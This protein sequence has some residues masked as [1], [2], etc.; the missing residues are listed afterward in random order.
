MKKIVF[1]F[2]VIVVLV[3]AGKNAKAQ[4]DS[5]N[6]STKGTCCPPW[7]KTILAQCL[8]PNQPTV[9]SPYTL[10]FSPSAVILNQLTAYNSYLN[11]ICP[12]KILKISIEVCKVNVP[13]SGNGNC[14]M[15]EINSDWINFYTPIV[16]SF[17]YTLG[18]TML[19]PGQGLSS[20]KP[21][22][23]IN[24]WYRI[25]TNIFQDP[26][27]NCFNKECSFV[28][29]WYRISYSAK[30]ATG[31]GKDQTG[32]GVVEISDGKKLISSYPLN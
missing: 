30:Q 28:D 14:N 24:Q 18:S 29:I 1:T 11:V 16:P 20:I 12:G 27:P 2:L 26:E 8:K 13:N 21:Q 15:L 5:G 23:Q 32:K 25:H 4:L 17:P 9:N 10:I 31:V 19:S 6:G 22:L 3:V 7:N